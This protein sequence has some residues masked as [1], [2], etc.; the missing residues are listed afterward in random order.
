MDPRNGESPQSDLGRKR[1]QRKVGDHSRRCGWVR[2]TKAQSQNEQYIQE[3]LG[4]G[5]TRDWD[6]RRIGSGGGGQPGHSQHPSGVTQTW[7][8]TLPLMLLAK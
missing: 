8:Q 6:G 4:A 5:G 2:G 3:T 7:I 1:M